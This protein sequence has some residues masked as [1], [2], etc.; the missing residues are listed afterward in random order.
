[1]NVKR[2]KKNQV[3]A[4][5]VSKSAGVATMLIQET[6]SNGNIPT[7]LSLGTLVYKDT[8]IERCRKQLREHI[9]GIKL[10]QE[11]INFEYYALTSKKSHTRGDIVNIEAHQ[12][13]V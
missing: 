11:F 7:Q 1:M 5:Y 10:V 13:T 8:S 6:D 3:Y 9:K 4:V 12:I 2:L